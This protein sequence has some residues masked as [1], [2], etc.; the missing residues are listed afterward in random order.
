MKTNE[1]LNSTME[2]SHQHSG[3][4]K[5]L[6]TAV[7]IPRSPRSNCVGMYVPAVCVCVCVCVREDVYVRMCM[8]QGC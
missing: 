7:A 6:R 1:I 5:V 3:E 8:C 2:H 4:L